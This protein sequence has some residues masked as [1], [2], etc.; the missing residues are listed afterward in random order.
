MDTAEWSLSMAIAAVLVV[1]GLRFLA[2]RRGRH[3]LAFAV[4][5]GAIGVAWGSAHGLLR[6][7]ARDPALLVRVSGAALL[8]A[9]V[10]V[11]SGGARSRRRAPSIQLVPRAPGRPRLPH[12]LE[13]GLAL[14]VA[15][16][17]LRAPG[18]WAAGSALAAVLVL[19]VVAALDVREGVAGGAPAR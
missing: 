3:W 12:P 7:A 10:V 17:A 2:P 14:V 11:A 6:P 4:Y 9:G 15:G 18:L 13:V 5:A 8:V 16:H 19:A 1:L